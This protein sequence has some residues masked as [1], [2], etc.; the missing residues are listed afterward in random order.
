[1]SGGLCLYNVNHYAHFFSRGAV[2]QRCADLKESVRISHRERFTH[3]RGRISPVATAGSQR[4][5]YISDVMAHCPFTTLEPAG[6]PPQP[7]PQPSFSPSSSRIITVSVA[8]DLWA[9]IE[10]DASE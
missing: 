10:R 4:L 2:L 8:G 1:M 3:S 9:V 5:E 6:Q 7:P